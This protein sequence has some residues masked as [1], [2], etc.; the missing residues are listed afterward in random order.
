MRTEHAPVTA[1]ECRC[2]ECGR[3]DAK[4]GAVWNCRSCKLNFTAGYRWWDIVPC[5]QEKEK[6]SGT[7]SRIV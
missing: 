2:P 3:I 4:A 6:N 7:N 5:K 1:V